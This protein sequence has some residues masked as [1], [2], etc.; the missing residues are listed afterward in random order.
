MNRGCALSLSG[1]SCGLLKLCGDVNSTS[2]LLQKSETCDRARQGRDTGQY[3]K[4]RLP[5]IDDCNVRHAVAGE[6][7]CEIADTIDEARRGGAALL[8]T[9]VE[10]DSSGEIGVRAD[11]QK[12]DN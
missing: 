4:H 11:Q 9:E 5:T 3:E 10:G 2:T 8:A 1:G 12:G 6:N 7:S